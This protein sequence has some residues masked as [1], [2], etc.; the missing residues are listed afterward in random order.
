MLAW[1]IAACTAAMVVGTFVIIAYSLSPFQQPAVS[2]PSMQKGFVYFIVSY[3]WVYIIL[4]LLFG[5]E[6]NVPNTKHHIPSA[7]VFMTGHALLAIM[8][9]VASIYLV[10]R[11]K[12]NIPFL[13][14][15]LL[16]AIAYVTF[17]LLLLQ[18]GLHHST[19]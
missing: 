14:A 3:P 8:A 18:M 12:R 10:R 16:A 19:L 9:V 4:L 6:H 11:N 2:V 13:V 15:N 5:T 1:I 17:I 7:W